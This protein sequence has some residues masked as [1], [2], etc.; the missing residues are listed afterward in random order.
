MK[1][2]LNFKYIALFF[3][4]AACEPELDNYAPPS[5][6]LT[7]QVIDAVTGQSLI[8][9]QPNGFRVRYRE[10][11]YSES[12]PERNFWG[13]ADGSFTNTKL[14]PNQYEVYVSDG[15]FLNPPVKTVDIKGGVTEVMFTVTPNLNVVNSS[16]T[17]SENILK[18][19]FGINRPAAITNKVKEAFVSISLN[20]NV[21]FTLFQKQVKYD[22]RTTPDATVLATT[23]GG[24][25]DLAALGLKKGY[26]YYVKIGAGVEGNVRYN[27]SPTFT[28]EYK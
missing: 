25:I 12:A 22:F 4:F 3:V 23:H 11:G 21:S 27:Y 16:A 7:G 6:T 28:I 20:P 5:E 1:K 17:L 26:T 8:T 9:E 10:I 18:V 24:A 14:F 15:P 2:I 19:S 13:K